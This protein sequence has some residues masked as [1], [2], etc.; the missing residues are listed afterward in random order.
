MKA[1]SVVDALHDD[2][3]A[4]SSSHQ[5][6]YYSQFSVRPKAVGR[7][8]QR[9]ESLKLQCE[10]SF[11]ELLPTHKRVKKKAKE[12]EE[13]FLWEKRLQPFMK[14]GGRQKL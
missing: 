4:K 13:E 2:G 10:G 14:T 6:K 7:A 3:E 9:Q 12:L 8:Y 1:K 5:N 11:G